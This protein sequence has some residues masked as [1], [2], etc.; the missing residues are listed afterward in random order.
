MLRLSRPRFLPQQKRGKEKEKWALVAHSG[1]RD[2]EDH[3]CQ[4]QIVHKTLGEKK[5]KKGLVEWLN[6][7]RMSA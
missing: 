7:V 6:R 2:Q 5:H 3:S 4:G 1:G